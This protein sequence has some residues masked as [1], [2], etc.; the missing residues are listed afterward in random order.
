[1][2]KTSPLPEKLAQTDDF[3][4]DDV[5][6]PFP[7]RARRNLAWSIARRAAEFRLW[8]GE[9]HVQRQIRLQAET[10]ERRGI[11]PRRIEAEVSALEGNVRHFQLLMAHATDRAQ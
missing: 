3:D 9:E 7:Y 2:T 11:S 5:V 8:K 1:M 10:M 4:A 6:I